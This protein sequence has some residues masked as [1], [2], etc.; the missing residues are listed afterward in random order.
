MDINYLRIKECASIQ[1]VTIRHLS[2][3][4]GMTE[5]GFKISIDNGNFAAKNVML[6]CE[7]L[8]ISPNDFFGFSS[9]SPISISQSGNQNNQTNNL[10][11]L[12]A[13]E[14]QL[15][16]KDK[17]IERLLNLLEK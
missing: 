13:L 7:K 3:L 15:D 9:D 2:Q 10:S 8:K 11:S 16:I 6:I 17:Q 5:T 4:V 1:G 14:K 12:S